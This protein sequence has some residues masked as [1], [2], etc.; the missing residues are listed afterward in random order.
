MAKAQ[1]F[2]LDAVLAL[3]LVLGSVAAANS[4]I[5]RDSGVASSH[6]QVVGSDVA[7]LLD[8]TGAL[9]SLDADR[10]R[11]GMTDALSAGQG[12]MVAV[13][14]AD[15]TSLTIGSAPQGA[16]AIAGGSRFFVTASTECIARWRAW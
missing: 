10:I 7:A 8:A 5:R 4:L 12:M 1:V 13:Q 16:T 11:L 15:G 6:L 2:A 9:A 14:C 3:L